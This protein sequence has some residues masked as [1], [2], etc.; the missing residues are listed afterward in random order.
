MVSRS[1]VTSPGNPPPVG[2][3]LQSS[4]MQEWLYSIYERTMGQGGVF[5]SL[6]ISSPN[7]GDAVFTNENFYQELLTLNCGIY[8]NYTSDNGNIIYGFAANVRRSGG[9]AF[10]VA[11]QLNAWSTDNGQ[12]AFGANLVAVG[13]RYHTG[14]L[15]AQELSP[16]PSNDDNRSVKVG[17]ELVWISF[18]DKTGTIGADRYNYSSRGIRFSSITSLI[19]ELEG[20]GV[21]MQFLTNSMEVE[22]APNWSAADTY[23]PGQLVFYVAGGRYYRAIQS[24]INQVPAPVSAYWVLQLDNKAIGIDFST[25]SVG[26]M[27]KI[28][29]AVRV[30]DTMRIDYNAEGTIGQ[31]FDVA[32][33]RM[34]LVSNLA[35]GAAPADRV[36]E[37][38]V[39]TGFLYR[40]NVFLI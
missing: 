9:E 20:W 27:A 5:P 16:V 22:N 25:L 23:L 39:I 37:V 4:E 35:L 34:V 19:G 13:S 36:L 40:F 28:G 33:G 11:G 8:S 12:A 7:S 14:A 18:A 29:S 3:D 6:R 2:V 38:D 21:G 15:F 26:T 17:S 10:V 31:L 32:T 30:R 1:I 24:S